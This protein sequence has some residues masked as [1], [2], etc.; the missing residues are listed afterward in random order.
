MKKYISFFTATMV[1]AV[2]CVYSA[3]QFST[4][5]LGELVITDNDGKVVKT[6]TQGSVGEIVRADEQS[7]KVSYG[8]DLQGNANIIVYANPEQ[9]Q[10]LTIGYKDKTIK[11]SKEAVLTMALDSNGVV[12][13]SGILGQITVDNEKMAPS[14]LLRVS[15]SGT[16]I[17]GGTPV[18]SAK[19]VS[20]M[21]TASAGLAPVASSADPLPASVTAAPASP[22]RVAR[23]GA[24]KPEV[25]I[26][27]GRAYISNDGST[28]QP[29]TA[30][31][32]IKIGSII[33]TE[34]GSTATL[35]FFPDTE[36]LLLEKSTLTVRDYK[37]DP[38]PDSPNRHLV[39]FL[40][41]GKIQ[42]DLDVKGKGTTHYQVDTPSQNFVAIGTNFLVTV[43][44]NEQTA[45]VQVYEGIVGAND[46]S[47]I[48][49]NVQGLYTNTGRPPE[50]TP[51]SDEGRREY[52]T[53][54]SGERTS[55]GGVAVNAQQT[56]IVAEE[57]EKQEEQQGQQQEGYVA[58]QASDSRQDNSKASFDWYKDSQKIFNDYANQLQQMEHP[59]VTP[60]PITPVVP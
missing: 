59:P 31:S 14:S 9:P 56:Q 47:K 4:N 39:L 30:D 2:Q 43:D 50:F 42:N 46:G 7:F 54:H 48:Y 13:Q 20:A 17:T 32:E 29:L 19:S 60:P 12:L 52:T 10:A 35:Y 51:I 27:I 33:R 15:N 58:G 21:P 18:A 53:R 40:S 16:V 55:E 41:T 23:S 49:A 38:T 44:D 26:V 6:M 5:P 36:T 57:R 1:V 45:F 8:K 28:E 25:G 22:V 24:T 37:Y 3:V 34:P 11:I